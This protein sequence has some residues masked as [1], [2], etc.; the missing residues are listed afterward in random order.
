MRGRGPGPEGPERGVRPLHPG[1]D[2]QQVRRPG[3][4][5]RQPLQGVQG[6]GDW[7]RRTRKISI[8]IPAGVDDGHT[9]RLRGEG[10]AGEH[11][12]PAGATSTS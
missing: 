7:C 10:E 9:L 12:M 11:G 3:L 8:E 1:R 6:D 2:L 5:N 4:D